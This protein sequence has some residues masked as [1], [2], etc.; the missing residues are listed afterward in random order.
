MTS[1]LLSTIKIHWDITCYI[2]RDSMQCLILRERTSWYRILH[3]L[4]GVCL[5]LSYAC[6]TSL[7]CTLVVYET[8]VRA[9]MAELTWVGETQEDLDTRCIFSPSIIQWLLYSFCIVQF[10]GKCLCCSRIGLFTDFDAVGCIWTED[11]GRIWTLFR[12]GLDTWGRI[13][14]ISIPSPNHLSKSFS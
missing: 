9:C 1:Y 5:L 2:W 4:K 6:E 8:S 10:H 7:C 14:T 3:K 11:P 12:E 13:L